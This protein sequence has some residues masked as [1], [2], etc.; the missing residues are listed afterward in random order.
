MVKFATALQK[1]QQGGVIATNHGISQTNQKQKNKLGTLNLQP[2]T[3]HI[4]V[5]HG[6]NGQQQISLQ[7]SN[8]FGATSIVAAATEVQGSNGVVHLQSPSHPHRTATLLTQN[9]KLQQSPTNIQVLNSKK[10]VL[11]L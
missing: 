1:S 7:P 6:K 10:K 3:V 5:Q 2:T 8:D 9:I 4:Q 11:F